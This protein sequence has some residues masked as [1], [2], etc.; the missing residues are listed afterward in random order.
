MQ[1][2]DTG[3]GIPGELRQGLFI[4]PAFL[5]GGR[6]DDS[7][8][9]LD[10]VIVQRILQLHGSDIRLVRQSGKGAVFCFQLSSALAP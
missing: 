3:P 5:G 7:G 8:G 10:L 6:G 9:G 2:I 4:R 1:V